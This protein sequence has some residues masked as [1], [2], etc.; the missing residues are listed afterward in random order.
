MMEVGEELARRGHEVTVISPHKYK[1]VP[2]GVTEIALVSPDFD[3]FTASVSDMLSNP[4][5][6]MPLF[7]VIGAINF[8]LLIEIFIIVTDDRDKHAVEPTGSQ[9]KRGSGHSYR[10]ED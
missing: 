1:A 3:K 4:D 7:E 8:R 2:P 10:Q 6:E 9:Y 5:K